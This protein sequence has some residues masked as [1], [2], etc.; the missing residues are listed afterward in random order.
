MNQEGFAGMKRRNGM[1]PKAQWV[2]VLLLAAVAAVLSG[3]GALAAG[4]GELK[5]AP[6]SPNYEKYLNGE[7]N[8]AVP[9]PIDWSYLRHK[10]AA[11]EGTNAK[12][13]NDLPRKLDLS[14]EDNPWNRRVT[15]PILDQ[16]T[17]GTCWAF[18]ATEVMESYLMTQGITMPDG[19]PY[20]FSRFHLAYFAYSTYEF[21]GITLPAF[22]RNAPWTE[23][24]EHPQNPIFDNGGLSWQTVA[25]L[26]RGTGPVLESDAPYPEINDSTVVNAGVFWPSYIPPAPYGLKSQFR[27][28]KA[29]MYLY[30]KD[31]ARQAE[32]IKN[33]L[34]TRGALGIA[35]CVNKIINQWNFFSSKTEF[36]DEIEPD[37]AV[38]LVGWDD[39]YDKSNFWT[40]YDPE[41]DDYD[42]YAETH[43]PHKNGAWRIQNSWGT[44]TDGKPVGENGFYWISYE[45]ES[46]LY[47]AQAMGVELMSIE[48]YDGIYSHDPLGWCSNIT[49]NET[50]AL[51]F[52]NAFDASQDEDIVGVSFITA[53]MGMKYEVRIVTGIPT[54]GGNTEGIPT[55]GDP[56]QGVEAYSQSGETEPDSIGYRYVALDKPVS[57]REG[58]RFAVVITLETQD[59][60][61]VVLPV[62]IMVPKVSDNASTSPGQSYVFFDFGGGPEWYDAYGLLV[63]DLSVNTHQDR[64]FNV[65]VKAFTVAADDKSPEG[66]KSSGGGCN[67]GALGLLAAAALIV[68][69]SKRSHKK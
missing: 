37:H 5:L 4:W 66:E 12:G 24:E 13:A 54:D 18:A 25:L 51:T 7:W 47:D 44:G 34:M 38:M 60:E 6:P 30:S 31:D 68:L 62:E 63:D 27:L 56:S 64:N 35:F 59:G 19:E 15:P 46:F 2:W 52:A 39:D 58:E 20:N 69:M 10:P 42:E 11:E 45:D 14:S 41:A 48:T 55:G 40:D 16:K 28:S 50:P 49:G 29:P 67:A 17:W 1:G 43:A 53:N 26:S 21:G 22:T 33:T 9:S 57:V 32:I 3:T 65:C 8:G 23:D 36:G 61:E